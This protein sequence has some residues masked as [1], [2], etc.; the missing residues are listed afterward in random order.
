MTFSVVIPMYNAS[1]TVLRTIASCWDQSYPV[2]EVI[3]VDDASTD[4]S[5]A[6]VTAAYG[7][8]IKLISFTAN[9]GPSAARNAGW[10][11]AAG[12]FVAFLDADDTWHTDR[13]AI[14]KHFLEKDPAIDF[15]WN[16]YTHK[17]YVYTPINFG[18]EVLKKTSLLA[19]C[20]T[21]PIAPSATVIRRTVQAP[22]DEQ[23]RYSEDYEW[24]LRVN[25]VCNMYEVHILL[26]YR[27][28]PMMA[29]GGQSQQLWKMRRGEIK[30][31]AS[32]GKRNPFLYLLFPLLLLWSIF[33]HFRMLTRR[34]QFKKPE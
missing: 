12:D 10:A 9:R 18:D 33:K 13:I 32:L 22:F 1:Q 29:P 27:S 4:D 28:R 24:V 2:K 23:M 30:S 8:K 7:E 31:Y 5:V 21:N 11:I 26:T 25:A 6:K 34:K 20:I 19:L 14:M 16:R 17:P 3:L 15:I